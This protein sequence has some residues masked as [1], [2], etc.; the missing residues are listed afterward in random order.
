MP[1]ST[2]SVLKEILFLLSSRY[3]FQRCSKHV[4]QHLMNQRVPGLLAAGYLQN[5]TAA[6]GREERY[7]CCWKAVEQ[8]TK[9]STEISGSSTE[10]ISHGQHRFANLES[11]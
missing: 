2:L 8:I 3:V 10:L 11:G 1:T 6:Q 9:E 7:V 5:L 4:F